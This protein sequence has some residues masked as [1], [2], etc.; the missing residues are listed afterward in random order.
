MSC[1]SLPSWVNQEL[2]FSNPKYVEAVQDYLE[3]ERKQKDYFG[4]TKEELI[5]KCEGKDAMIEEL[6]HQLGV[7]QKA[8]TNCA[9]KEAMYQKH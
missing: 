5:R 8:L 6:K 2:Y 3:H 9:N 4:M 1:K 7:A